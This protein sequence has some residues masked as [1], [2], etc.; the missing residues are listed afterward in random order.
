MLIER[1]LRLVMLQSTK[2]TSLSKVNIPKVNDEAHSRA[3][4][5]NEFYTG[6]ILGDTKSGGSELQQQEKYALN[7]D[8]D[9]D[10]WL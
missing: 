1:R 2:S 8:C 4:S 7:N 6:D 3:D 10:V 5:E 9:F